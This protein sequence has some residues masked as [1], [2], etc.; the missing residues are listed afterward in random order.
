M[1][2]VHIYINFPGNALEALTFYEGVFG[3][4]ISMKQTFGETPYAG[5][6]LDHARDKIMHA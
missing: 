3:T 6:V 2:Q 4:K 1:Q 5:P